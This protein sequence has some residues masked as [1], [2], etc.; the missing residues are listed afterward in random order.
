MTQLRSGIT[1]CNYSYELVKAVGFAALTDKRKHIEHQNRGDAE[2]AEVAQRI[3]L[4]C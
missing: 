3:E 2:N 1:V 4:I